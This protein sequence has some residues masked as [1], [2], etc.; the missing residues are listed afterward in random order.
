MALREELE[1]RGDWLFRKRSYLPVLFIPVFILA[2]HGYTYVCGSAEMQE[3]WEAVCLGTSYLGLGIRILTIGHTPR[4]TSGRSNNRQ[5]AECLNTTGSYSVVRNPL[6]LGNFFMGLGMALFA[7]SWW[8]VAIYIMAFWLYY[9]RIILAEEAFLRR[10]F[11]QAYLEWADTTPVFIPD[12]KKYRKPALPFSSRNVLRREYNGFFTILIVMSI[13]KA[14]GDM[15]YLGK[16]DFSL[17]WKVF[18][19][20]GFSMW[21]ILRSLKRHTHLLRV[22]GR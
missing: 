15:S 14:F 22:E 10:T 17:G 20:V 6:Y 7:H 18:M 1:A 21:L 2:L 8:L 19:A 4:G 12:P 3:I 16:L 13:L 5:A 9:E 11:G